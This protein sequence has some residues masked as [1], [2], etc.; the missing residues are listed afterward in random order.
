MDGTWRYAE[1]AAHL[2]CCHAEAQASEDGCA[3]AI[4]TALARRAYRRPVTGP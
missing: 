2:S 4:V 3:E 1:P